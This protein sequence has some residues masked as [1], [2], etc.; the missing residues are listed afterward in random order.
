M[1]NTSEANNVDGMKKALALDQS[2]IV[3]PT[4]YYRT[5][6]LTDSQR[7]SNSKSASAVNLEKSFI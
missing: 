6:G 4:F 2:F 7:F 3:G 5:G 1:R